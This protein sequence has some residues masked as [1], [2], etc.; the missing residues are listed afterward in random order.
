MELKKILSI[1]LL[2][3]LFGCQESVRIGEIDMSVEEQVVGNKVD[4][5][6]IYLYTFTNE[7]G[8]QAKICNYG[9]ILV[10]LQVP[11]RQGAMADVIVGYALDRLIAD[12][13]SYFGAL[14]GRYGNRIARGKFTLD[15]VEYTLAAND[16]ENHLHGGIKGFDKVVWDSEP[17]QKKD[18][19]GVKLTYLSRDGEE[20]FPGNLTVTVTYKMTNADELKIKYKA[21][22]DKKTVINLTNHSYFNI[23][24]HDSGNTLHHEI[25]INA[26]YYTPVDK[27]LIPTGELKSVKGTPFDLTKPIPLGTNIAELEFSYDHN[28]VL[29]R[30]R[31]DELVLAASLY[32]SVSGRRMEIF[33]TEPG[34][35]FYSG[36]HFDGTFIGKAGVSYHK[37][38]GLALETQ[39]FPDSPNQPQFPSV[40][41]NPGEK[42]HHLTVHK[43]SVE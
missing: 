3:S 36:N 40:V 32:D 21:E 29:N 43:F 8:L 39:H 24:G 10:S 33:T 26:D 22:T 30:E 27:G 37:H 31:D 13:D 35:Q 11:D 42:Y 7:N 20:G 23:A 38:Q 17:V 4:G 14:I 6:N 1:I 18:C 28:F 12:N 34:I 25:M 9:G 5:K 2:F 16:R 19:V 15:G 41:L